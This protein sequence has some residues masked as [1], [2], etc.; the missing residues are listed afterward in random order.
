[1]VS[2]FRNWL[3]SISFLLGFA[4]VM[5]S[6]D[7]LQRV[8]KNNVEASFKIC[9]F[10]CNSTL[11]LL[12]VAGVRFKYEIPDQ[13]KEKLDNPRPKIFISNHQ[14]LMDIAIFYK[15]FPEQQLRF[16]AKQELSKGLPYVS[17]ALRTIS[18]LSLIHI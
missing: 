15:L 11:N 3:F 9:N 12:K 17:L 10:V 4:V 13:L 8:F 1:M 5:V 14:S 6:A 7:L 2:N 16:I 18:H